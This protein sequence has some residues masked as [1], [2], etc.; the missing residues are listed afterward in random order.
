MKRTARK[1]K[2]DAATLITGG[3]AWAITGHPVT[4]AVLIADGAQFAIRAKLANRQES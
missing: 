3:I 1:N 4:G 2:R